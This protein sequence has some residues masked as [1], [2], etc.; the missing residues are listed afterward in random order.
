[1]ANAL[2]F[3]I[4]VDTIDKCDG[5]LRRYMEQVV[6]LMQLKTIT[7]C[8]KLDASSSNFSGEYCN[9]DQF[10][11]NLLFAAGTYEKKYI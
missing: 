8:V 10:L 3:M 7:K 1:M 6:G 5:K 11:K 2:Y 9:S 4:V